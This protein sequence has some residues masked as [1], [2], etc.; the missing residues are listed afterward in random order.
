[1]QSGGRTCAKQLSDHEAALQINNMIT[2]IRSIKNTLLDDVRQ[3]GDTIPANW[4]RA[5]FDERR[6]TIQEHAV[7]TIGRFDKAAAEGWPSIRTSPSA[8]P[9]LDID[10]ISRAEVTL[11]KLISSR[12]NQDPED[13]LAFDASHMCD[14]FRY[15]NG[16]GHF[17]NQNGVIIPGNG[18]GRLTANDPR[19]GHTRQILGFPRAHLAFKAQIG[20]YESLNDIAEAMSGP[21]T[22]GSRTWHEVVD[23]GGDLQSEIP[24]FATHLNSPL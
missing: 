2:D 1:M 15:A 7:N 19:R 10:D 17:F 24:H 11:L 3:R 14:V 9:Y 20:L 16:S 5:T 12:A 21:S 6:A 13:W 22:P 23:K 18:Y 8:F 4:S